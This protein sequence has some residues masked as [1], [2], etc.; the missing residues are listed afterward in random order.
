M[1]PRAQATIKAKPFH[2]WAAQDGSVWLNFHR[3]KD[4]FFLRFP[5]LADFHVSLDGSKALC[6]LVPGND[7]ATQEHLY[8]NQV[9]P[10]MQSVRGELIFH[11]SAVECLGGAI[12]FFGASGRGK[13]TLVASFAASGSPFLTDDGLTLEKKFDGYMSLPSHPS[14]RMWEDSASALRTDMAALAPPVSF[15]EKTRV[16]AGDSLPHCAEP[17]PLI[18]AFFLESGEADR[19]SFRRLQGADAL[20]SWMS[21]LFI[22]DTQDQNRIHQNFQN[23]A[24]IAESIPSIALNYPR[25]YDGLN[26]LRSAILSEAKNVQRFE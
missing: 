7:T 13:S 23:V 8:L 22:L 21:N 11:A 24:N 19:I 15:T 6:W 16:L 1:P 3:D 25:R 9:A 10:L 26:E 18:A 14:V 4:G 20:T 5:G 2:R 12:A 17:Q